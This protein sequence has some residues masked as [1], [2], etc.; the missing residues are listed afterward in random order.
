MNDEFLKNLEK[1][2]MHQEAAN[3]YI[4]SLIILKSS[5]FF[6]I[7]NFF[8]TFVYFLS[9]KKKSLVIRWHA[10]QAMAMQFGV[11]LFNTA[12][13]IM[14]YKSL[15]GSF[16][17]STPT[18]YYMAFVFFINFIEII[19]S[20][21][22]SIQVRKGKTIRF[23]LVAQ[24]SDLF[25][26]E[27]T[28]IENQ[29]AIPT[30]ETNFF[31]QNLEHDAEYEKASNAY[32]MS[33]AVFM[34][35]IPLPIINLIATCIF[36]FSVRKKSAFL[37][38]HSMQ[39]LSSQFAL[40]IMNSIGFTFTLNI[41]FGDMLITNWYIAYMICVVICNSLEIVSTI[42]VALKLRKKQHVKFW[43][44][45]DIANYLIKDKLV[46]VTK[47]EERDPN[48]QLSQISMQL[49][50][51]ITAIAV[52]LILFSNVPF[53]SKPYNIYSK[54]NEK[55]FGDMVS[56]SILLG[57]K[58]VQD[59]SSRQVIQEIVE[60]ICKS[61]NIDSKKFKIHIINSS[62]VNAYII[63]DNHIF[64]NTAL[65]KFSNSSK[66]LTGV[67]AHEIGHSYHGHVFRGFIKKY[68]ITVGIS[69]LAG[70]DSQT[71]SAITNQLAS[72]A[73]SRSN[74]READEFAYYAMI[75]AD[76]DPIFLASFFKKLHKDIEK[77]QSHS[78]SFLSTHPDTKERENEIMIKRKSS[79]FNN[80]EAIDF[81]SDSLKTGL[82]TNS[83]F[84]NK[85]RWQK[86]KDQFE[87]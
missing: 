24:I 44:F 31:F 54:E 4:I 30:K 2:S 72:N 70:A 53:L 63:P 47:E 73:Y 13:I 29:L 83:I 11:L 87:Y 66:E 15:V 35:G 22:A 85:D 6:P 3:V 67:I 33:L 60:K 10:M 28:I 43:I 36:Y 1:E 19:L 64:V 26:K 17:F 50:S 75:R 61:S 16:V 9:N 86:F 34:S 71:L 21:Y 49:F 40:F 7:I 51:T 23:W 57:K 68:I 41:I 8:I 27:K 18:Y 77:S 39:A 20:I 81:P 56:T 69:M 62:E 80:K 58:E 45:G 38:W 84:V 74:E 32:L 42:F 52:F 25:I 78:F 46:F 65:I 79:K 5:I 48:K 55:A 14:I 76:L 12:L 82:D 37:R 59:T